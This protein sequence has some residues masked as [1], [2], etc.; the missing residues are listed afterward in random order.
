MITVIS[1]YCSQ[2][3]ELSSFKLFR[4]GKKTTSNSYGLIFFIV[5]K[6]EERDVLCDMLYL[7]SNKNI[8]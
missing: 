7:S 6:S 1:C 4:M 2:N 8:G 3:L 5:N